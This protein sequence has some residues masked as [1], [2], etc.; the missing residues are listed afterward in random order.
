MGK[1]RNKRKNQDRNAVIQESPESPETSGSYVE[2]AEITSDSPTQTPEETLE[3]VIKEKIVYRKDPRYE[4]VVDSLKHLI[5][6]SPPFKSVK[7]NPWLYLEWRSQI[8]RLVQ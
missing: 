7:D 2:N 4:V 6:N 1:Q 3:P 8:E 5:I